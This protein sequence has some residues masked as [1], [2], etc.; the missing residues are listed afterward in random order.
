MTSQAVIFVGLGTLAE[1]AETDRQ[2]WNAAFRSMGM[3]W[4]WSWDTYTELMR[5]GGDRKPAVRFAE[6]IGETIDADKLHAMH[7]RSFAARMSKDVPLRPGI[8]AALKWAA[9][10]G[11]GLA[12]ISRYSRD[13]AYPLLGATARARGGIEFDTVLTQEIDA[14]PVPHP[15]F[16]ELAMDQLGAERAVV[17]ADTP[18]GAAA[19]LDA[20][21]TTIAFPSV[22]AEEWHF[23]AGVVGPTS[24]APELLSQLLEHPAQAAAE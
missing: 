9:Q 11:R 14:K 21:Q 1:C 19:G 4:D 22:L 15:D 7:H 24:L 17:I 23:P 16:I 5:P 2:A 10:S 13:I 3:R 6:F 8:P 12:F 18:A 20:G